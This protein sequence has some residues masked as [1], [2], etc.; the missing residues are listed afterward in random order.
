MCRMYDL[1]ELALNIYFLISL[2]LCMG[3]VELQPEPP[4]ASTESAAGTQV[5]AIQLC[6][7]K[8]WSQAPP[9]LDPT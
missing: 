9:L 8:G 2:T 3:T 6:D 5:K 4:E 7:R 1:L